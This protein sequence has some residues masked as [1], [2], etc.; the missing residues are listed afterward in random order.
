MV[1]E[2]AEKHSRR[3]CFMTLYR[4][5]FLR[6]CLTHRARAGVLLIY[7]TARVYSGTIH[8]DEG[9]SHGFSRPIQAVQPCVA[10]RTKDNKLLL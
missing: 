10:N 4:H 9:D 8:R 7:H 6:R 5:L 3:L 1:N 2:S